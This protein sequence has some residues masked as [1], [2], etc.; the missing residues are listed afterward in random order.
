M[1]ATWAVSAIGVFLAATAWGRWG[2]S[3]ALA[4]AVPFIALPVSSG[5]LT[6]YRLSTIAVKQPGASEHVV[7]KPSAAS[8]TRADVCRAD[9]VSLALSPAAT[10]QEGMQ[11]RGTPRIV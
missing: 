1:W 6:R 3:G 11:Y 9:D 2:I 5:L 8:A 10:A 7:T 4:I